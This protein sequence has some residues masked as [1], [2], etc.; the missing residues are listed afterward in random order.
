MPAFLRDQRPYRNGDADISKDRY[1]SRSW[2]ELEKERLWNRV[3]QF[4]CREEHLPAVGDYLVYDIADQ[5]FV[6]RP[7]GTRRASRPTRTPA[8]TAAAG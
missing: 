7:H 1:L 8:C 4:A 2:H 5:S 3:W 6:D